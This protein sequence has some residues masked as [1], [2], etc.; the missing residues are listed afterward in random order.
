LDLDYK[1]L[2]TY[3]RN[4]LSDSSRVAGSERALDSA[5]EISTEEIRLGK[6]SKNL[7]DD[8]FLREEYQNL[9]SSQGISVLIFPYIYSAKKVHGT[10]ST[11]STIKRVAPL[12]I[13]ATLTR[14]GTL[15]REQDARPPLFLRDYLEPNAHSVSFGTLEDCDTF[16]SRYSLGDATWEEIV[17]YAE[18][19]FLAVSGKTPSQFSL[20]HWEREDFGRICEA[21]DQVEARHILRLYNWL[22]TQPE[23]ATLAALRRGSRRKPLL[24]PTE[25]W[26]IGSLY[27]GHPNSS[28]PLAP[29]QRRTLYHCITQKDDDCISVVHGPPG[30][31]KTTLI[32]SMVATLWVNAAL[33]REE[34]PIIFTAS[35]SNQAVT[36]VN[37][38]FDSLTVDR[39][40][41]FGGRWLSRIKSYG[42]YFASSAAK[43]RMA[44]TGAHLQTYSSLPTRD[45]PA[46]FFASYYETPTGLLRGISEF[47]ECANRS[48]LSPTPLTSLSETQDYIH[49]EMI[50][51]D[52][53]LRHIILCLS[54]L[55]KESGE[56][57]SL[58]A[59]L[60]VANRLKDTVEEAAAFLDATVSEYA[61]WSAL[62]EKWKRHLRS[63]PWHIWLRQFFSSG[64]AARMGRD[65]SFIRECG[66]LEMFSHVES[67]KL[68]GEVTSYI[69][70]MLTT[71]DDEIS[72]KR[73]ALDT[74][75][76]KCALF[77]EKLEF[78]RE[79]CARHRIDGDED[80]IH[81]VLDTHYRHVLFQLSTHYWEC[82]YLQEVQNLLK[83]S[84]EYND[85]QSPEKLERHYRRI[86]KLAPCFISTLHM[87]P[88]WCRTY[89][90]EESY[91][92]GVI[93]LL[94]ID[95][96][97]QV[98]PEVG[99][100]VCALAKKVCVIGDQHQIEPVQVLP[101]PLDL[102]NV[103]RYLGKASESEMDELSSDGFLAS[104][105]S[106]LLLA[107]KAAR[108]STHPHIA[109]GFFLTEHRRC[110]PN[111][112]AY[113]NELMYQGL[114][115][116]KRL[117]EKLSHGLPQLGWM[118]CGSRSLQ[119]GGSYENSGEAESIVRWIV[120]YSERLQETYEKPLH[121]IIAIITPFSAQVRMIK[122]YISRA[123]LGSEKITVGTLHSMQGAERPVV[124]FSPTY[125]V[126]HSG[127]VFFARNPRLLNV[128]VSRAKD[129]FLVFGSM[130]LFRSLDNATGLLGK[131]LFSDVTHEL[132]PLKEF[133]P[134][135]LESK[136]AL[137]VI[138][139]L[140]GHRE[141]LRD[142]FTTA[143]E[144][145]LI[146]SPFIAERALHA[147]S[148]PSLIN[149]AVS[150]G[151][152]VRV[153]ADLRL[154]RNAVA[155][156]KCSTLLTNVGAQVFLAQSKGIHCKV[157]SR[158]RDLIA[159][160]SFNWLAA[161]RESGEFQRFEVTFIEE[162]VGAAG[163][164]TRVEEDLREVLGHSRR[165]LQSA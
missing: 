97:A 56:P 4:S 82:A 164:I 142:V 107:Q 133:T 95:E 24:T 11:L 104:R 137:K 61:Q 30:T 50:R 119:R 71:L 74:S 85:G 9:P 110:L 96:A 118:H 15:V 109:P 121:Q 105:G 117:P 144:D 94:I 43:A 53:E 102:V 89:L 21:S 93:D 77:I 143:K 125:G 59:F 135:Y 37:R 17:L 160:G 140:P 111:I 48:G 68:R 72:I 75:T 67:E 86:A 35:T 36:T 60:V 103:R 28:F 98:S 19:L 2:L 6:V 33:N 150:R 162:G 18:E 108:F 141:L 106:V 152:R 32:Q 131:H 128:A 163:S 38:A 120:E 41:Q 55:S 155:L 65:Y 8:F 148:I 151:V 63:E 149:A 5:Y 158:D 45:Q 16:Y 69:S 42:V 13:S 153:V 129:S 12:V 147:D 22:L 81:T 88:K 83:P 92:S 139:T 114:L 73:G 91:L 146:V 40:S 99:A 64:K 14:T 130:D 127:S 132:P 138:T 34:C 90:R 54:E 145:V 26:N 116:S 165:Y 49:R 51:R 29:S 10:S 70:E 157:V 25:E 156:K 122:R 113:C 20:P 62:K 23:S 123:G 27:R 124:L 52:S 31:G 3:W 46:E 58:K 39:G 101:E 66:L 1:A 126:N 84:S 136:K 80:G 78:L 159:S 57:P 154:H 7:A 115:Q 47:L 79:W 44:A 161:V 100:P 76:H 87:L 112:I 134:M